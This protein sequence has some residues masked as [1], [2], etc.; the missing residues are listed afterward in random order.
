MAQEHFQ[1]ISLLQPTAKGLL[2]IF[3]LQCPDHIAHTARFP[4]LKQSWA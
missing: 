3:Q 4:A 2:R 1:N